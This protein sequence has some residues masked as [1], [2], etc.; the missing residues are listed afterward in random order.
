RNK[1]LLAPSP[2]S[3]RSYRVSPAEERCPGSSNQHRPRFA[4]PTGANRRWP[5]FPSSSGE[6]QAHLS[7]PVR[8]LSSTPGSTDPF[9]RCKQRAAPGLRDHY[10]CP[11]CH[12]LVVVLRS[13][14]PIQR[15]NGGIES[16][17]KCGFTRPIRVTE[18][19][20]LDVWRTQVRCSLKCS[21]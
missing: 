13:N 19:Q 8:K 7:L 16:E 21:G 5:G 10:T 2:P 9:L 4:S 1:Q 15:L 6:T 17:C 11:L 3:W 14:E 20:S 12:Q 18:I